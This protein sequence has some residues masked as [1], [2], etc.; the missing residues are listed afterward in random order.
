M[1]KKKIVFTTRDLIG[2]WDEVSKLPEEA[3]KSRIHL[4]LSAS[5]TSD[6]VLML[7]AALRGGVYEGPFYRK[8]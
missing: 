5:D 1:N 2:S 6:S 4:L 8:R 3:R 7:E